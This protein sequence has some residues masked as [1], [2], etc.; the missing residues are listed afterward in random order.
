[1]KARSTLLPAAFL[2][3]ALLLAGCLAVSIYPF[4]SEKDVMF[5]PALLGQWVKVGDSREKWTFEKKGEQTFRLTYRDG[6]KSYAMDAHLF[7]LKDQLF[8]DLFKPDMPEDLMPPPVPTH[9]LLRVFQLKPSLRMAA[10]DYDWL[11]KLIE[12]NPKAIRHYL[13]AN[14]EDSKNAQIVLTA[15]TPELQKFILNHL[16]TDEAWKDAFELEKK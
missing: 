8:L 14:G 11:A 12:K 1:M 10:L 16:K 9:L 4:Y 7:R 2:G 5:E 15:D 3:L 6:E 13:V